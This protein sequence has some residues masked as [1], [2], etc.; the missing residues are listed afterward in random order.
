[1]YRHFIS[2]TLFVLMPLMAWAQFDSFNQMDEDG[3]VTRRST[4]HNA[5]SLGTDK[6]FPHGIKLRTVD[7][8]F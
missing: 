5:D 4:K 3:N 2:L 6:E 7:E 1:M 8:R